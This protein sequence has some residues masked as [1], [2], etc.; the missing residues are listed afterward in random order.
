MKTAR[1]NVAIQPL[2]RDPGWLPPVVRTPDYDLAPIPTGR[3]GMVLELRTW[4]TGAWETCDACPA[5]RCHV[6]RC[7]SGTVRC[8]VERP[9]FAVV[10]AEEEVQ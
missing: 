4:K 8:A 7:E 3:R 9:M 2:P 6:K 1:K 10:R 5:H